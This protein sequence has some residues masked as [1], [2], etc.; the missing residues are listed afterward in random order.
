MCTERSETRPE[1]RA[2]IGVWSWPGGVNDNYQTQG[3][4]DQRQIVFTKG[5]KRS[6]VITWSP[7]WWIQLSEKNSGW[8]LEVKLD[9]ER[10]SNVSAINK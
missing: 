7:M 6:R 8:G 1:V 4:N 10:G 2:G 3:A 9:V 5:D